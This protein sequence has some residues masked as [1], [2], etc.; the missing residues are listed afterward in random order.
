MV[1]LTLY[2]GWDLLLFGLFL[3]NLVFGLIRLDF[4][5]FLRFMVLV[6]RSALKFLNFLW[7]KESFA[8]RID[9]I[10]ALIEII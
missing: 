7:R 9:M 6:W 1:S 2:F 3:V 10:D 5:G 8:V 4:F